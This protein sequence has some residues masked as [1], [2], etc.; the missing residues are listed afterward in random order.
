M[1]LPWSTAANIQVLFEGT[2]VAC[3]VFAF[4]SCPMTS[5]LYVDVNVSIHTEIN[6]RDDKHYSYVVNVLLP[7]K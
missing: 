7:C 5:A 6:H 4:V 1:L 2:A 3:E